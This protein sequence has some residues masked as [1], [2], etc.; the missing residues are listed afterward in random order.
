MYVYIPNLENPGEV[1]EHIKVFKEEGNFL[2]KQRDIESALEKYGFSGLFLS[3]LDIE[4]DNV[5]ASF[6]ELGCSVASNIDLFLQ[7]KGV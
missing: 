3:Y 7:E 4:K 1:L 2:F 6:S 5:R